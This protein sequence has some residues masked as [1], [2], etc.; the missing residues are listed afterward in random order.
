MSLPYF[1]E[2]A[3]REL[4][5]MR[6][7]AAAHREAVIADARRHGAFCDGDPWTLARVRASDVRVHL[8]SRRELF[9]QS[10]AP[11]PR[12][13]AL[14][15]LPGADGVADV[16]I[17]ESLSAEQR[18]KSLAH[19]L[20]H[21]MWPR[22]YTEA[23]CELWA[24]TFMRCGSIT[25]GSTG[26]E[27]RA[28]PT[29]S[30]VLARMAR[31]GDEYGTKCRGNPWAL[32]NSR[33]GRVVV[34]METERELAARRGQAAPRG[35]TLFGLTVWSGSDVAEV[36]LNSDIDDDEQDETLAHEMGH[37]VGREEFGRG[38]VGE[39]AAESFA[40]C[41]MSHGYRQVPRG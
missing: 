36:F 34:R 12:M 20:A 13:V 11:S 39:D 15:R 30:S 29:Q 25:R 38:G 17:D 9:E 40:R 28:V 10:R 2:R 3:E 21:L 19:E 23:D 7:R 14:I 5:E 41:F 4:Q 35:Q 33:K 31:L 16:Y 22:S 24:E 6:A 37:V 8:V 18:A 1:V 27:G 32:A 26:K